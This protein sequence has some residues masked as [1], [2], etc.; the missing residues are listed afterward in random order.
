VFD[1]LQVIIQLLLVAKLLAFDLVYLRKFFSASL[2][3]VT[4]ASM[5][6]Y[7]VQSYSLLLY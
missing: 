4:I 6:L 2:A 5:E 1:C 3:L 7:W